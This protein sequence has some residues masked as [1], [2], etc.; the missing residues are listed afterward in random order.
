MRGIITRAVGV[1][2]AVD[3][4]ETQVDVR[5]G[6]LFLLFS[7]GVTNM[8]SDEAIVELVE[9]HRATG[10]DVLAEAIVAAANAAGGLDNISVVLIDVG[11]PVPPPE[12]AARDQERPT[13]LEDPG[14][15]TQ[16][17]D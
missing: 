10:M 4:E 13:L 7:D 14:E 2:G 6:D 12:A 8:I 11:T 9:K 3:L 1:K 17:I 16:P 5:P 15:E